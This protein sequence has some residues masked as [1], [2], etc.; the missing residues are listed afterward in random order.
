[1]L[2]GYQVIG[3]MLKG[4]QKYL[5]EKGFADINA[6]KNKAVALIT[7]HESLQKTPLAYPH[8]NHE[9]CTRCGKCVRICEE[10][11]HQVLRLVDGFVQVQ[12]DKCVG[13]GLCRYVC[14]VGAISNEVESK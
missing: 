9:R 7:A 6:L 14:P 3:P 12:Q 1:M 2:N 10:S 8:I 4:L 13:C 5:E 11:E